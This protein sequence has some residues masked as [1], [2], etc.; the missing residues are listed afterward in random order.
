M[1]QHLPTS[2][3]QIVTNLGV[4]LSISALVVYLVLLG[5]LVGLFM[6]K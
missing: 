5:T 2:L 6:K 1:I 3:Q 4:G